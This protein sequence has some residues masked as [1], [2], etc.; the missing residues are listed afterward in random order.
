MKRITD[1]QFD[2]YQALRKQAKRDGILSSARSITNLK[3]DI[4]IPIRKS[5]AMFALLGT[6]PLFSC[7]GYDYVGQPIHKTHEHRPYIMFPKDIIFPPFETLQQKCGWKVLHRHGTII[8][9]E[10]ENNPD[11]DFPEC[12]HYSEMHN[13]WIESL[14]DYLL[15]FA[16]LFQDS[17]VLTDTN[18]N[19]G[20]LYW[21]YPA[22]EPWAITKDAVISGIL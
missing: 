11:W 8:T 1:K 14:E 15:T 2:E 9:A 6:Q 4:D 18:S 16:A 20:K 7:C 10:F 3:D 17:V 12:I 13:I 21:M 19:Y 5:V 22:K